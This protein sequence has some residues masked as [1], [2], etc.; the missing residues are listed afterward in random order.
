[1]SSRHSQEKPA[2]TP[3]SGSLLKETALTVGAA[4]VV[5][6]FAA[7]LL[8]LDRKYFWIDDAQSGALPTYSELNRAWRS[9]ELPL[10]S[11]SSW[12]GGAL[13]AEFSV[14][15]FSPSLTLS[16]LLAFGL[17]LS[18]PLTAAV[19]ALIHLGVLGAGAFRLARR[20]GLTVELALLA[21]LVGSIN[22]W[23]ILWGAR[24]WGLCLYSF[25]WLPWFWWALER[26][27]AGRGGW[28]AFAPA[29]LFLFLL[30]TAG[31]PFTILMAGLITLWSMARTWADKRLPSGAR[32]PWSHGSR[33]WGFPL[34]RG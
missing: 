17:N 23:I 32:R 14:G 11:R 28:L 21:T 4:A 22:G 31:W 1:M 9:G 5:D 3:R 13:A 6:L 15:D 20:Q 7:S 27:R 8:L 10:L 12:R 25:A 29:G 34:R 16:V 24:N 26:A 19:L 2:E 33:R 18:L 30:I